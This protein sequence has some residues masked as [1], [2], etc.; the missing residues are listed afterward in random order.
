MTC[1]NQLTV[2]ID[3]D[4][5]NRILAIREHAE[6]AHCSIGQLIRQLLEDGLDKAESQ[7][8]I[9]ALLAS[10]ETSNTP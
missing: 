3:E 10:P 5:L 9:E 1:M 4:T 6:H 7:F 8:P 2:R